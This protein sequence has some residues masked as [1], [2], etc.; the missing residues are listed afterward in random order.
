VS[1]TVWTIALMGFVTLLLVTIAM[2]LSL[3]QFSETPSSE[4]VRLAEQIATEF[5]AKNVAVRVNLNIPPGSLR[6]SYLAGIHS[7]YS[8]EAQNAEMERVAQFAAAHYKGRDMRYVREVK[9]NRTEI[10]GSGCFQTT[11]EGNFTL[12]V[13]PRPIE[14]VQRGPVGEAPVPPQEK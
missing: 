14:R 3:S 12:P 7:N 9:V 8:V 4:W 1:K 11:Y 2:V 10:H 6:V 5:K 13:S